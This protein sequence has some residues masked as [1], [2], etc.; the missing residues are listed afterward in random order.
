MFNNAPS[1]NS[2]RTVYDWFSTGT[3]VSPTATAGAQAAGNGQMPMSF[4][5]LYSDVHSRGTEHI[6]QIDYVTPLGN[7]N[8]KLSAGTKFTSRANHSDSRYFNVVNGRMSTMPTTVR[9][10]R[11]T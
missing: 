1:H 10:I 7:D 3:T 5:D 4:N 6:G 2:T 8:H 9:N 11:T